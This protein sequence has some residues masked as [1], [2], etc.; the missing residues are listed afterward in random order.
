MKDG[1]GH[2]DMV[3]ESSHV[4]ISFCSLL[5]PFHL[6]GFMR[7]IRYVKSRWAGWDAVLW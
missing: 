3:D 5:N 2:M 7:K 6:A 4:R 1:S